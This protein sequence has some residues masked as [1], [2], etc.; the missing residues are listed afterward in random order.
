MAGSRNKR[1]REVRGGVL[2]IPLDEGF[3]AYA[4]VLEPPLVAFF[5]IRSRDELSAEEIVASE[6]AFSVWVM[7]YAI[8]SG[9]WPMVAQ[10][11]IG[12]N[13]EENPSFFKQDRLS[14]DL[15]IYAGGVETAASM[16]QVAHLECAAVWD[17]EHIVE[18]LHDHFSG[19]RNRWV[20]S[21]RPK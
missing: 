3:F 4:Q 1:Q 18:R 13:C 16:D 19:K 7:K 17:P 8:T 20:D 11:E 14:G 12:R 2:K 9:E 21:M 6:V 5:D 10:T 15:S